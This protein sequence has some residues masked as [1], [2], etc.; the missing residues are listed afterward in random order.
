LVLFTPRSADESQL[1][2]L[3]TQGKQ[4]RT[5]ILLSTN[6]FWISYVVADL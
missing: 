3:T 6:S 2:T 4:R 5:P 1:A